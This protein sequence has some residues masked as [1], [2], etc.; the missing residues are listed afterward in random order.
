MLVSIA[1]DTQ[2]T[3]GPNCSSTAARLCQ[4]WSF[5]PSEA[6]RVEESKGLNGH[7]SIIRHPHPQIG[8]LARHSYPPSPALTPLARP[9]P[10]H[11]RLH[12]L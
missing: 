6:P 12:L 11:F 4:L 3:D 9:H 2:F 7:A 8:Q 5:N 10:P 1:R